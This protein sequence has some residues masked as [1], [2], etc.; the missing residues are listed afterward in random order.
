VTAR[1][2]FTMDFEDGARRERYETLVL[3]G[4]APADDLSF[5]RRRGWEAD[6]TK[7]PKNI[8]DQLRILVQNQDAKIRSVSDGVINVRARCVGIEAIN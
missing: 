4:A 6:S 5:L 1:Y 2:L 8:E 7:P 3:E